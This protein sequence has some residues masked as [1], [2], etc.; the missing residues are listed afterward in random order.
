MINAGSSITGS[1]ALG[2]IVGGALIGTGQTINATA[3]F[4]EDT[5]GAITEIAD[6]FVD[7]VK[8]MAAT[9]TNALV[10]AWNWIFG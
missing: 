6:D 7:G 5:I 8:D 4:V 3:N 10:D 1:N 2:D 9:A